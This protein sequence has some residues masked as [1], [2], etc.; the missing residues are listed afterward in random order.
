MAPT[1]VSNSSRRALLFGVVARPAVQEAA[2]PP[3]KRPPA[4]PLPVREMPFAAGGPASRDESAASAVTTVMTRTGAQYA[5]AA[6]AAKAAGASASTVFPG[7]NPAGHLLRRATF[8]ARPSDVA[9]V[10]KFGIDRWIERQLAPSKLTDTNGDAAW[11]LYPLACASPATIIA[12]TK[13]FSWDAVY[14]TAQASLARQIFSDRQLYE[15]V[16][17]IFANHLHVPLP[18]EQWHT[19]PD[20]L[21][22]VVRKYAL[23]SFT[24]MLLAAMR[25][26]AMLTFLNNDESRK[27]SVNENLGRELLELHTVGIAGGYTETDVRNS[28]YILSG[29]TWDWKKGTYRYDAS[30]HVTGA[31]KVLGFTHANATAAGGEAVGDAYLR[32]LA[33]HP[34]TAKTIA[35]KIAVRFVSDTPSDDLVRRLAAVYLSSGTNIAATVR[36]VFRS[37]DFWASVGTR[38]RR[39]LEDAVGTL[40]VLNVGRTTTMKTPISWLYWNLN[41]AGHTPHGWMPP[42][43]Y[44]DVAAAWLGAGSMIQRWNLHRTFAYGWWPKFAYIKPESIVT[45]TKNMTTLQWTTAVAVR[46]L[47]VKPSSAHL[48]AVIAGAGL[49]PTSKAPTSGWHCGKITTLLL[50]SPYFQLR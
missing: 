50:D 29:R 6:K 27:N 32:Y 37:S 16:V 17:D 19:A 47:G 10:K 48:L 24:S 35:R 21:K 13:E 36:A 8:G 41:E 25:H 45:R 22:N 2:Q 44:P 1:D 40:R 18:G 49:T 30:Q 9:S 43:G 4:K 14:E 3:V 12:K 38:M 33:K 34:A 42:N 7:S 28:A 15:V 20:Y 39:P 46:V 26:P 31:V 23:G 11:K 5:T